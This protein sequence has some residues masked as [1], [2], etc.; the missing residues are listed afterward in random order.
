MDGLLSNSLFVILI[1]E[2]ISNGLSH[3]WESI[4]VYINTFFLRE[5][6]DA[7]FSSLYLSTL[8]CCFQTYFLLVLPLKKKKKGVERKQLKR[9]HKLCKIFCLP[10]P[11]V[12]YIFH[13]IFFIEFS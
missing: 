4:Q 3:E 7:S 2:L 5:K 13:K 9:A 10:E 8:D 12:T 6:G 11:F 1:N